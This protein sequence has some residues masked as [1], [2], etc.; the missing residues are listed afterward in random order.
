[1]RQDTKLVKVAHTVDEYTPLQL[2]EFEK[3]ADPDTGPAYFL[4]NY[5]NI[6]HA[7]KG[8]MLY[9]PFEYQERLIDSYHNHRFTINLMPRQTGKSTTAAGYLLWYAMF[10]PDSTILIAAH[11]SAGAQEIMSRI[12]YAYEL[13]PDFIRAGVVTY[14]K[15]SIE[16]ENGSRIVAETTTSTTG[17][18]MSITLLYSDELAFV[19]TNIAEDFWTSISPT[20]STGGKAIITSTPNSDEDKFAQ[21]WF[22]ANDRFD[23]YGEQRE[24]GANGFYPFRAYWNEH[25]DR[26]EKWAKE[27]RQRIGDQKF[28]R[29]HNCEFIIYEETL[30]N[31]TILSKTKGK[32]PLERVGN[33]RWYKRI[34]PK[35]TYVVA[36]DP[37]LGTGGDPAAIQVFELPSFQQVAEW[38]HN[39]TRIQDQVKIMRDICIYINNQC[40]AKGGRVA[41]LYYSVENNTLGEAA[42]VA[43]EELGEDTF[44]GLFIS[45]PFKRG[46]KRRYRKGFNTSHSSKLG[47]CSKFKQLFETKKLVVNSPALISELKTFIYQANS[48][49]ARQ[50]SHDD[51]VMA[52]ILA[53][54]MAQVVQ[55]WD[56]VI[57]DTLRDTSSESWDP[58]M[59]VFL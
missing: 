11:K 28:D 33:C 30:I 46:S 24:L 42:L 38:T 7:T 41:R 6:Q 45:E 52:T 1:M 31:Q 32:E 18:G 2:S 4:A 55:D 47:A 59:P 22:E 58:P 37:S 5:F 21:I 51:L 56:P 10:V 43:I 12:R 39:L 36:L 8:K 48:Y 57:Y 16:F 17:R 25:P 20:L 35:H 40:M 53:V 23:E 14:N 26:D 9:K 29:E 50:G 13:C 54:R 34:K 19:P 3:C 27:E 49:S 15:K 44:P